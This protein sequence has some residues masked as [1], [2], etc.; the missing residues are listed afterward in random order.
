MP[1]RL[2]QVAAEVDRSVPVN[3]RV[4]QLD[5]VEHFAHLRGC[6]RGV[7]QKVH[8]IVEGPLEIDVVLPQ[9][10][11]GV[12]NQH[13][14]NC[15]PGRPCPLRGATF[16]ACWMR[17]WRATYPGRN[18]ASLRMRSPSLRRES[19]TWRNARSGTGCPS[20]KLSNGSDSPSPP[21]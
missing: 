3:L 17:F 1:I 13:T 19:K 8:E 4:R 2:L 5:F 20:R 15:F 7:V 6:Q 10:V 14:R 12:E 16:L 18:S 11:V 21:Q 9:R